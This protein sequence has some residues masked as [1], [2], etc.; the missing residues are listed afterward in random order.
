MDT[1]EIAQYWLIAGI[2]LCLAEIVVPGGIVFFIGLGAIFV[3]GFL[4][5]GLVDGWFSA[6][7]VWFVSS[8]AFIFGLRGMLQKLVPAKSEK[9]GTDEDV[10][11]YNQI[12]AVRDRI[13]AKG[14]GR[15]FFRGTTWSA[16]NVHGDRDLEAGT[17]VRIVFRDNLVWMV[18]AHEESKTE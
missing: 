5:L 13:P 7:T 11:A 9:A 6:L 3:S 8:L 15:V 1:S 16:R 18:E 17:Q 10:D 4:F 14:E 2:M 12:V